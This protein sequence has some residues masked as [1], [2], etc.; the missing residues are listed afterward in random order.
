MPWRPIIGVYIVAASVVFIETQPLQISVLTDRFYVYYWPPSL[1]G[2][3]DRPIGMLLLVL[4][5][6]LISYRI[7]RQQR[8]LEGGPLL[9]PFACFL[10]CVLWGVVNGLARGGIVKVIVLEV[11]PFWYLFLAYL[12]AY[13]SVTSARQVRTLFWVVIAGA[14]VKTLQGL[15]IFLGVLQGNLAG[16]R[17]IMAHEESFFL[18][19]MLVLF[20]IFSLHPCDRRQYRT[21]GLLVPLIAVVLIANQRRVAYLELLA[22]A[23]VAWLLAY[24]VA[25][26]GQRPRLLRILSVSAPLVIV[27]VYA[28]HTNT[29]FLARPARAIVSMFRPEPSDTKSV[30]S[31][32]YRTIENHDLLT[33]VRQNPLRGFGF[34]LPFLQPVALP[35]ISQWDPY[36]RYIPHNTIYW[37]WMRLGT[38]G[39]IAFWFL[40]GALVLHGVRNARRLHDPYLR[41]VAL[42]VVAVTPMEILAAYADYQLYNLRNV[43][44]L[45]LLAGVL[46]KLPACAAEQGPEPG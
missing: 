40:L 9:V 39:F 5:A 33:T 38:I 44:Y 15:Y 21:L 28:F 29:S 30:D 23:S 19:A 27:Y 6:G 7:Q 10:L 42:F 8:V 17:E 1:A 43:L 45:G 46:M 25:A 12:L 18:A 37:V 32:L 13:N 34:G 41:N 20:I 36:Y 2:L 31:N 3:V 11:R 22:G 24:V 26:P 35:D 16:H 14:G 4:F